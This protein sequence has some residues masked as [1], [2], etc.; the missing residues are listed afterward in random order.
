MLSIHPTCIA[1]LLA[2][3]Y[4][5]LFVGIFPMR[6]RSEFFMLH[7]SFLDELF[8]R[9]ERSCEQGHPCN[10]SFECKVIFVL[11]TNDGIQSH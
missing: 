6:W 5:E 11:H 9:V 1:N 10:R 8:G 4:V 7:R 3:V 2:Y